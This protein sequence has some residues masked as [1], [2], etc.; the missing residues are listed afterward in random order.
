MRLRAV[1]G[2]VLALFVILGVLAARS[3]DFRKMDFGRLPSRA[4]W[5]LPE[6][7]VEALQIRLGD[8][9]ADLGAGDGYFVAFLAKAVGPMGKLYAVDVAESA[10]GKLTAK[11]GKEQ[12]DNVEVVKGSTTD[13]GLPDREI[14]LVFLC[15]VYHH[16]D[17]RVAYFSRLRTDL[18]PDGRVAVV[19]PKD[20]GFGSLVSP[21]GHATARDDLLGEMEAAGYRLES[22]FDFL[23]VQNLMI[24]RPQR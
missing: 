5:Q 9:V 18:A 20:H 23:P 11:V 7:V 6:E 24:F 10:L 15:D 16:I 12:L 19:E 3:A 14:D 13:P 8:Q 1:L 17:D 2:V 22:S 4:S 21:G